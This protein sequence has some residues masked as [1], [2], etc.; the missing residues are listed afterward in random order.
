MGNVIVSS[1]I[2]LDG[3]I[4]AP[5][6]ELVPPKQTPDIFRWFIQPNLERSGVFVYGRVT[7]E[8][9]V[10]Y[11]TSPAADPT[12]AARLAAMRKVVYSRTLKSA[13]WGRVT[14]S[15]GD[16]LAADVAALRAETD[17]DITI[18][19]SA[20][21]VTAFLAAGLVDQFHLLVNP[22]LLG[23]GTPLFQGGFP[24]FGLD[25][26][27]AQPLDSGAVLLDYRKA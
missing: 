12:A 2:S 3:Y 13:D 25:L 16:D 24:R 5:N 14:I 17:R 7:Y 23:G 26:V 11:W 8:F 21:V 27:T 20:S 19:G 22:I 10:G 6:R 4:E 9:M 18:L 15:R 1:F